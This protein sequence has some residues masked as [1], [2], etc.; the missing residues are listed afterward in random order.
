MVYQIL[1]FYFFLLF[2]L[3]Y[4]LTYNTKQKTNIAE[5][6]QA[7]VLQELPNDIIEVSKQE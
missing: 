6:N 7:I 5:N 1:I 2:L 4:L 3:L